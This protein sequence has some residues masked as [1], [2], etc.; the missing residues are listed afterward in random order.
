MVW[1][2]KEMNAWKSFFSFTHGKISVEFGAP[3][4]TR[5]DSRATALDF[6]GSDVQDLFLWY[7]FTERYRVLLFRDYLWTLL[8]SMLKCR[9]GVGWG[10]VEWGGVGSRKNFY[11]SA[12]MA[13]V[14]E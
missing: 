8:S 10:R 3:W 2:P 6:S 13:D 7:H 1:G 12:I 4:G 14:C 9:G 5:L 11:L